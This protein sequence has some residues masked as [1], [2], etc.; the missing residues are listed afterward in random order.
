MKQFPDRIKKDRSRILTKLVHQ[1]SWDINQ[2]YVGR[3]VR[4][5]VTQEGKKG[6]R[7]GRLDN[8]KPI[9]VDGPLGSFVTC[10]VV[11]ATST[12]LVGASPTRD[13]QHHGEHDKG[14]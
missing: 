12:Y 11:K 13:E 8:Y 14:A 7:I 9:V 5:L 2:A 3:E 1:L 4:A 6:R 10:R